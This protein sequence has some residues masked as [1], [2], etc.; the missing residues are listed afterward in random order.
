MPSAPRL[1]YDGGMKTLLITGAGAPMPPALR[2][3]VERGSTSVDERAAAAV[4]PAHTLDQVDRL[5]FWSPGDAATRALAERCAA[6]ERR[7]GREAIVFVTTDEA[8]KAAGLAESEVFVWPRDEDR[9]VMAF[10]TGA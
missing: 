5:V 7:T 1:L 3:V 8:G 2:E 4:D 10:M 9:L 6:A